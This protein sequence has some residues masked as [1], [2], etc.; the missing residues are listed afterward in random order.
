MEPHNRKSYWG[1]PKST[2]YKKR[3][4]CANNLQENG[5]IRNRGKR[6]NQ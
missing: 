6:P 3:K 5:K 4:K 1:L 2:F